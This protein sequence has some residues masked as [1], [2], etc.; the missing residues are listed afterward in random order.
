MAAVLLLPAVA[1]DL[2]AERVQQLLAEADAQSA[3]PG[4][5]AGSGTEGTASGPSERGRTGERGR[6]GS[7][8]SWLGDGLSLP[9]GLATILLWSF[10]AAVVLVLVATIVRSGRGAKSPPPPGKAKVRAGPAAEPAGAPPAEV[11]PDHERWAN[12]GDFAAALRA[13]LQRAFVVSRDQSGGLPVHATAR[14]LLRRLRGKPVAIEPLVHLVETVERVHF[15]GR[16]A[17]RTV[18]EG[19]CAS[20][21]RWE[22]VW[23]TK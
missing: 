6:R 1:Q 3:L 8:S 11:V 23:S 21:A 2:S 12:A 10:V 20:L 22:A 9:T 4:V 15:G 14:E 13:L 17:D 5:D 7:S 18:Y 16:P 19:A